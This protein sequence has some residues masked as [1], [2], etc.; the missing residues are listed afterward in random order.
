MGEDTRIREADMWSNSVDELINATRSGIIRW[1]TTVSDPVVP[2][3]GEVDGSY[4]AEVGGRRFLL[5]SVNPPK[6]RGAVKSIWL[7][8]TDESGSKTIFPRIKQ[9][10]TLLDIVTEQSSVPIFK[11]LRSLRKANGPSRRGKR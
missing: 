2:E 11:P 8:G 10:S 4:M 5:Q 7:V 6:V 1:P 3:L 9:L